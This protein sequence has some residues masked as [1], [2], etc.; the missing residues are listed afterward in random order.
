MRTE[1]LVVSGPRDVSA[2]AIMDALGVGF[3]V[4]AGAVGV[5]RRC[6]G[7]VSVQVETHQARR[8]ATPCPI[9]VAGQRAVL[10]R[11]DDLPA[12]AP[13]WELNLA[14][15]EPVTAG[16]IAVAM[17]TA[18]GVRGEDLGA[19]RMAES[20]ITTTLPRWRYAEKS[21]PERVSLD[22]TDVAVEKKKL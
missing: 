3:G 20:G 4:P 12:A 18:S 11:A 13:A 17:H 7:G 15:S 1:T 19:I 16:A 8:V 2:G 9:R 10:R 21:L 22:G 14:S 6:D 5:I